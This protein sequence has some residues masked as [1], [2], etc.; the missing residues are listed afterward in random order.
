MEVS[1]GKIGKNLGFGRRGRSGENSE[2]VGRDAIAN[3]LLPFSG[4]GHQIHAFKC[5][6]NSY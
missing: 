6:V 5:C 1:E 3:K 4:H 2:G